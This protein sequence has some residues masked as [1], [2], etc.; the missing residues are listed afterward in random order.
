MYTVHRDSLELCFFSKH[1]TS[2]TYVWGVS[3]VLC[4]QYGYERSHYWFEIS[5][6][7]DVF[8]AFLADLALSAPERPIKVLEVKKRSTG[9]NAFSSVPQ[10]TRY[11]SRRI[12]PSQVESW[13]LDNCT[14]LL[15]RDV[16]GQIGTAFWCK[17]SAALVSHSGRVLEALLHA[18]CC[19]SSAIDTAKSKYVLRDET[20]SAANHMGAANVFALH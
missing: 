4:P 18:L 8:D 15:L 14:V 3:V 12:H 5:G 11:I 19:V 9:R 1:W 2:S 13:H 7:R 17:H 20:C 10:F 6:S 16:D